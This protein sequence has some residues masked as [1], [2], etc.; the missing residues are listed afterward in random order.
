MKVCSKC[1]KEK[2]FCEFGKLS[3]NP[4]GLHTRCKVCVNK[5]N[6]L[7]RKSEQGQL[8]QKQYANKTKAIRKQYNKQYYIDMSKE[9]RNALYDR[10]TEYKNSEKGKIQSKRRMKEYRQIP[11]VKEHN[12]L[13]CLERVALKQSVSDGSITVESMRELLI[14]QCNKCFHCGK[15]LDFDTPRAIHLD[16]L[17]PLSKGGHHSLHNVAYSCGTCNMSKGSSY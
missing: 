7:W 15:D 3:R 12:R 9:E 10:T 2:E 5:E 6:S 17:K 4:D 14:K 13:Q 1:G 8:T 16:H 11:K